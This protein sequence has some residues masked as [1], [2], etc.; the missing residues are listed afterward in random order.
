MVPFI[1]AAV[2]NMCRIYLADR[3]EAHLSIQLYTAKAQSR[4]LHSRGIP[5]HGLH[6]SESVPLR[7]H[8][9]PPAPP[10]SRCVR[11][12]PDSPRPSPDR[13]KEE[14]YGQPLQAEFSSPSP[15]SGGGGGS[16]VT[17]E[18]DEDAS[19][20]SPDVVRRSLAPQ[21]RTVLLEREHSLPPSQAV[22]GDDDDDL[23]A[24]VERHHAED[25]PGGS[26]CYPSSSSS[27]SR[28]APS[29]TA[30]AEGPGPVGRRR[31]DEQAIR[32]LHQE[33]LQLLRPAIG[34]LRSV[35]IRPP[36]RR[37]MRIYSTSRTHA[38]LVFH[39]GVPPELAEGGGSFDSPCLGLENH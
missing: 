9:P 13:A 1:C 5:H 12:N 38:S 11:P 27:S 17:T 36:P 8:N 19:S 28:H 37:T 3:Y 35:T 14:Q 24:N 31:G 33:E 30:A 23:D 26:D 15:D 32:R 29:A 18:S 4:Q 16:C 20:P 22:D 25:A 10:H 2:E 21:E 39:L 7:A 6:F 34:D